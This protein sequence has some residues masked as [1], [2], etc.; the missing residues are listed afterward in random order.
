MHNVNLA[1][2]E[3]DGGR[4]SVKVPPAQYETRRISSPR[5]HDVGPDGRLVGIVA[6]GEGGSTPAAAQQINVVLNWFEELKQRVPT[7]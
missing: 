5:N 6:G 7:K 2:T 3:K 1:W 4:T